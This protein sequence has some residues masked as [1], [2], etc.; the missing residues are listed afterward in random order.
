MLNYMSNP[1]AEHILY[2]NKQVD[3]IFV[4]FSHLSLSTLTY[5]NASNYNDWIAEFQFKTKK[6]NLEK[7]FLWWQDLSKVIYLNSKLT[8]KPLKLV[9]T[10]NS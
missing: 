7:I 2:M 10:L 8:I 3:G 1:V 5:H 6:N 4:E 9:W